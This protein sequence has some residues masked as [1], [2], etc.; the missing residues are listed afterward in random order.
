MSGMQTTCPSC[1]TV[2]RVTVE[3]L[4]VRDGK[5]RCGKCAFVFNAYD[6]LVTP[7]ETVS[8]IAPPEEA[9]AEEAV[10]HI[11][12]QPAPPS[13]AEPLTGSF[14]LPTDEQIQRETEEINRTIAESEQ[15]ESQRPPRRRGNGK[16]DRPRLEI[17]P[18]LQEK[19]HNL[20]VELSSQERRARLIRLAWAGGSLLLIAALA[21][22]LAYFRR[23]WLAAHYPASRP[24][25]EAFCR[26]LACRIEPLADVERIRLEAS[27][28][29]ADPE[30]PG[31]VVLAASLRNLAPW[32]QRYPH[33]QLTLTDGTGRAVARRHFGPRDYLSKESRPE[34]GLPANGE[35]AIRLPLELVGIEAVGY[36]LLVYYPKDSG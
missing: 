27:E 22:Q 9:A 6:T 21:V 12:L 26:L 7:I 15:R 14:P 34:E 1:Q 19:L 25:L 8:L 11:S 29:T 24:A 16:S 4:Q 23:D 33:L 2:F 18:E 35:L 30:R 3:Q 36:R 32:P 31:G 20:Q 10:E 28:L 17:T 5:V 13:M